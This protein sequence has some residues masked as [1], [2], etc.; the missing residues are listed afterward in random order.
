MRPIL[1]LLFF[2]LSCSSQTPKNEPLGVHLNDIEVGKSKPQIKTNSYGPEYAGVGE[3]RSV[4][5]KEPIIALVLGLI[6][7]SK[8]FKSMFSVLG[9]ISTHLIFNPLANTGKLDAVQVRAVHNISS[10]S[11]MPGQF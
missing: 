7:L 8:S 2:I 4:G 3:D 10:P 11:C 9:S 5:K 6:F 1:L